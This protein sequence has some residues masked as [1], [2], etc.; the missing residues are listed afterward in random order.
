MQWVSKSI[1]IKFAHLIS[2]MN[3]RIFYLLACVLVLHVSTFAQNLTGIWRGYFITND[4]KN[5]RLEFQINISKELSQGVS[6]SWFDDIKFYGKATMSGSYDAGS[7][8]L[9]IKEIKTVEVRQQAGDGTCIMNYTLEYSKSGREE[10]LEGSYLGRSEVKTG[11]NPYAWGQCG[12]G[13][14]FLRRVNSTEFYQEPFLKQN[15]IV[16]RPGVPRPNP[17][18]AKTTPQPPPKG[19]IPIAKA[20]I[21]TPKPA[22]QV[23]VTKPK[24]EKPPQPPVAVNTPKPRNNTITNNTQSTETITKDI[25]KTPDSDA[26]VP[27]KKAPAPVVIQ[28][29]KNELIRTIPVTAKVVNVKLY[30]NGEIDDDTISIYLDNKLVLSQKRLSTTPISLEVPID[31]NSP[32]HELT[33]VAENLGRIPPNTSL[34]KVQAGT[35]LFEVRITSTEQKNAVVAFSYKGP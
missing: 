14:V 28:T 12:G 34:M 22:T 15:P 26:K 9:R 16:S 1:F 25:N 17:P 32:Y 7:N 5:Y 33:M 30:D 23:P 13:K 8:T 18:V 19:N 20:P 10:Y 4:R 2:I 24:T 31:S 11:I 21:K 29:R 6:Y 3:K 35:D 27:F